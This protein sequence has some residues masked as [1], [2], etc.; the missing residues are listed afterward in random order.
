MA[1]QALTTVVLAAEEEVLLRQVVLTRNTPVA[2]AVRAQVLLARHGEAS[3]EACAKE[4]N[5][6][7]S[8]ARRVCLRFG[9]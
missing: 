5:C 9:T 8:T 2:V 1:A 7:R 6:S 4:A 3:L